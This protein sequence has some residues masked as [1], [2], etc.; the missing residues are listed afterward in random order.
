MEST[1]T[2]RLKLIEGEN[3]KFLSDKLQI[4]GYV[5]GIITSYRGGFCIRR[6]D[7]LRRFC[8]QD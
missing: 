2:V 8:V 1:K 4:N 6:Q 7:V 3:Q 5:N